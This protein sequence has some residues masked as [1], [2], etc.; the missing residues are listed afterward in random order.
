[1]VKYKILADTSYKKVKRL[2]EIL[3]FFFPTIRLP[4]SS[5]LGHYRAES[6]TYPMLINRPTDHQPPTID[7]LPLTKCTKHRP[8]DHQSVRNLGTRKHLN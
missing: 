7:N 4:H 5:T 1:M 8:T 2:K 6:V 3:S